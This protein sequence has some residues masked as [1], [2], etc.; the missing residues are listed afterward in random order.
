MLPTSEVPNE[1][2]ACLNTIQHLTFYSSSGKAA[3][4]GGGASPP[5]STGGRGRGT[6]CHIGKQGVGTYIYCIASYT[7]H[8]GLLGISP[9]WSFAV[10]KV[11][12]GPVTAWAG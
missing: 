6:P 7:H 3:V 11:V 12:E 5:L 4:P 1:F 2:K 9:L 8:T 10:V